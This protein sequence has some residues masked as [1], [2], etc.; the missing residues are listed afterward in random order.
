MEKCFEIYD[1]F[2]S[3]LEGIKSLVWVQ[4]GSTHHESCDAAMKV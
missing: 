4:S 2:Q 1:F 3:Y